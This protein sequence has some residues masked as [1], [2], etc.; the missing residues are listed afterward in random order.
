M[1]RKRIISKRQKRTKIK[2]IMTK[3]KH[4]PRHGHTVKIVF[5]RVSVMGGGREGV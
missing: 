3:E 1:E 4:S 5:Q 2:K